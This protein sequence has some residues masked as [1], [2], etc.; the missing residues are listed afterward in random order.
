MWP[1]NWLIRRLDRI[2][3]Q[4]REVRF[5]VSRPNPIK[6]KLRAEDEMIRFG[7][8]L[9]LPP[10]EPSD[11]DEIASGELSVVIG[12]GDTIVVSTDKAVQE[13]EDRVLED[14]QFIGEQG[15]L[16][17][18]SFVYIDDAGNKSANPVAA[19]AELLDTIPPV[20][21]TELGF[22]VTGEE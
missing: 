3:Q 21:P 19:T 4:I 12:D 13:T 20:D 8:V 16:V 11:W 2:E 9:P 18:A 1:C 15:V 5:I 14:P 22:K 6:L 17:H 7:V 10:A